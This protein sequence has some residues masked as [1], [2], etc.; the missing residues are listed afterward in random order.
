MTSMKAIGTVVAV[1]ALAVGAIAQDA[2]KAGASLEGTWAL[3]SLNGKGL[4]GGPSLQ[5]T[6]AAGKY[7]QTLDNNVN[8]RGTYKIDASKKPMT[9]DLM[10]AE[11]DD[12]G[13]TQLGVFEV[14][15]DKLRANLGFPGAP[16]RP[17]DFT[18]SES[19]LMFEAARQ[20]KK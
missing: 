13:K 15:G 2:K 5:L 12:A 1:L 7:H 19:G 3:G 11:G 14:T 17:K 9:I 6:F 10:I 20:V 8:E 16:E 4:D 18:I